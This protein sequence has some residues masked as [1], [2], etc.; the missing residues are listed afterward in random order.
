MIPEKHPERPAPQ[1]E[2]LHTAHADV[3]QT[4]AGLEERRAWRS[5]RKASIHRILL[6][7]I[8][9]IGFFAEGYYMF[10]I[11]N[12][13]TVFRREYPRCW[14]RTH[15]LCTTQL[16]QS[17]T[18]SQVVGLIAGMMLLGLVAG[19]AGRHISSAI[20]VV[21]MLI[22]GILITAA[23][24]PDQKGIFA[25]FSVAQAVLGF[26]VGG[27]YLIA[28]SLAMEGTP[29]DG[30]SFAKRRGRY[31]LL[32]FS[33]Q[34]LG[35]LFNTVFLLIILASTHQNGPFDYDSSKLDL[36]W[37]LSFGLGLI[38]I[39]FLLLWRMFHLRQPI[40][41]TTAERGAASGPEA[42]ER[43]IP[44]SPGR[45][46]SVFLYY[47]SSRLVGVSVCWFLWEFT[48]YGNKLFQN[49]FIGIL[50][51]PNVGLVKLLEWT[52]L[53]SSVALVGYFAAAL[54]VDYRWLGRFRLQCLGFALTMAIYFV[55]AARFYDLVGPT[56]IHVFRFLYLFSSFWG[57]FGPN[58]TTWLIPGEIFPTETRFFAQGFAAAVG[59]AGALVAGLIFQHTL[60]QDKFYYLGIFCACG[61]LVT[62]LLIPDH[63]GLDL[64]LLDK[65][66]ACQLGR[67]APY[68]GP[69]AQVL[70]KRHVSFVERLF[71]YTRVGAKEEQSSE[72][73][74]SVT[75]S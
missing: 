53:N 48:F 60:D 37:R 9:G 58:A 35:N 38:P 51:G 34:G 6:C 47:Y 12:V 61:L 55:C 26:G 14:G 66:W 63:T 1:K 7:A 2:H 24:A 18:Y 57:Q 3:D 73:A 74:A 15:P 64:H 62:V 43:H 54:L 71:G 44:V 4:G 41:T 46:L 42:E 23:D 65:L 28:S 25:M 30:H 16:I 75:Q 40:A 49:L 32:S 36:V 21:F 52:L 50:V 31:A 68:S 39:V 19:A 56:T 67:N 27:E 69:A 17:A 59:K 13:A 45:K 22:G 11:G 10:A 5:G 29:A 70:S 33:M 72:K 20:T 8:V